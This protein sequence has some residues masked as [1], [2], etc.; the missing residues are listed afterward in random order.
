MTFANSSLVADK[1]QPT[2]GRD[3]RATTRFLPSCGSA[4]ALEFLEI[5]PRDE[6]RGAPIL[7]LHGAFDGAWMWR[8]VFLSY[9]ADRGRRPQPISIRGH[10]K[11]GGRADLPGA[12]LI[13]YVKDVQRAFLEFRE[14]P[15]VVA[16]SLGALIAQRLLS[17]ERMC[18][19]VLLTPIPP[20]GMCLMSP[21]L[22]ATM[23]IIWPAIIE[24]L[25]GSPAMTHVRD[26]IF[27]TR[28][29]STDVNRHV[30]QMVMESPQ[31]LFCAHVPSVTMP[32]FMCGVP[33]LVISGA[34]TRLFRETLPP[35]QQSI[36]VRSMSWPA[37]PDVCFM[38]NQ[39]PSVL[40]TPCCIGSTK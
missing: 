6:S 40:P 2:D 11:S 23:P 39:G 25:F 10:G 33:T 37:M 30:S 35:E 4:P 31:V 18:A 28:L 9:I 19:L 27:S 34:D 32:A 20:E 12:T 29:S 1:S 22:L 8:E 13:D 17:S 3:D 38:L 7:C 5:R 21:R 36:T 26:L 15:I 14:P 24:A 16:H